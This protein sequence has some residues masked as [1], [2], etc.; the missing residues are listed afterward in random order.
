MK[1]TDKSTTRF[2][3]ALIAI[4]SSTLAAQDTTTT[5]DNGLEGWSVSGRET[6]DEGGGNPGENLHAIMVDVFG[7]DTR[8]STN[9]NFL[10]DYNRFGGSIELS[11]DIK[12]NMIDFFGTIVSRELVVDLRDFDKPNGFTWASAWY[13][14]GVLDSRV[15]NEWVTYSIIIE[16]TT[17]LDLPAGWRGSGAEDPDTFE[18][19]LPEGRTFASVLESIDQITFT[20]FVPGFFFGFTN[21]DIQV[22]NITIRAIGEPCLADLNNDGELNFFDV[23]AFL[24]GFTRQDPAVDFDGN[25]EFNFFDVSAFLTAFAAGCP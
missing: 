2:P 6:I 11:I 3:L 21:F 18:P 19:I 25:G 23:S 15:N 24:E 17:S 12:V 8:N 22:D 1:L 10:G 13:S 14:L 9:V 20:T 7:A 5:F 4:A 16:D